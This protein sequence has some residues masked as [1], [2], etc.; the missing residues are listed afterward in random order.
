MVGERNETRETW[1]ADQLRWGLTEMGTHIA[2][3][4]CPRACASA[5]RVTSTPT[6]PCAKI[7]ICLPVT[8]C[9]GTDKALGRNKPKFVCPL[10]WPK[11]SQPG[12]ETLIFPI[13]LA[14]F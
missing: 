4:A 3:D 9:L 6:K 2:S 12:P 10:H 1:K 5:E 13:F 14:L 7:V 8:T 11:V